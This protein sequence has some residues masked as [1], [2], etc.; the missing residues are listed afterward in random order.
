VRV[1]D[2]T[3]TYSHIG[4]K[5]RSATPLRGEIQLQ[6]GIVGQLFREPV[7]THT[8]WV[9]RKPRWD[10]RPS[11]LLAMDDI[12]SFTRL[13]VCCDAEK[14]ILYA[15]YRP[16]LRPHEIPIQFLKFKDQLVRKMIDYDAV[17]P[18]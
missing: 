17:L 9:C 3:I 14:P 18:K 8:F 11:M 15:G 2:D 16:L 12:Y 10:N 5:P 1:N 6:I 4:Y 7:I 13:Y